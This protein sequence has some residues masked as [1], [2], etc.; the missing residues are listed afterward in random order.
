MKGY[1]KS[2]RE[3]V[4]RLLLELSDRDKLVIQNTLEEDLSLFHF[5]WANYVRNEFGLWKNNEELLK[6]CLPETNERSP[7]EASSVIMKALWKSLQASA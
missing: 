6:D 7:D 5:T 4:K 2:V 1:P 3:A